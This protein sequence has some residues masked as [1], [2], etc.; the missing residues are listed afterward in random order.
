MTE[1]DDAPTPEEGDKYI[2]M[3]VLIPRGYRYQC[4]IVAQM[5]QNFDGELIVIHNANPKLDTRLYEVV[6]PGEE[7]VQV[8]ADRVAEYIITSF[9]AEVN[10]YIVF[11][12]ILYHR[13]GGNYISWRDAFIYLPK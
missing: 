4:T 11:R 6:F 3:E 8:S 10:K 1:Q 7:G 5:K 13:S 9:N 2:G 12:E